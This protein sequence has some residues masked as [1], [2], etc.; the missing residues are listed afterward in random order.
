MKKSTKTILWAIGIVVVVIVVA[1]I[2]GA[3]NNAG[4]IKIGFIGS[5]TG[6]ASSL[7]QASKS[8]VEIAV[9][10][11]NKSGGINGR[12]IQ[13]IYE[14]GKC[15]A[16]SALSAGQ[17]LVNFDKVIAIIGGLCSSETSSFIKIASDAKIPVISYCSSAPSLSQSGPYFFRTYPSDSYQGKFAAEYAY[18]T[19]QVR[20]VAVLYHLSDWGTGIKD[21]FVKRFTELGGKVVGVEGTLQEVRDYKTQLTK[22][23]SANPDYIYMA[24]YAEGSLVAVQQIQDLGIK[25]KLLGTDSWNDSKFV[26]GVNKNADILYAGSTG[27]S[28]EVFQSKFIAFTG[29][30]QVPICA[31]QAY[32]AVTALV[33]AIKQVGTD[34]NKLPQA[35]R[36]QNFQ[37]VTGQVSFDGNG[38]I[39]SVG[40]VVK[41]I[42]DGQIIQIQ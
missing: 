33:L 9:D 36:S 17:K 24:M 23:K 2:R 40:Y 13:V 22:I 38:D 18:N 30:K 34:A 32:D 16:T 14:D 31:P 25:T 4:N 15:L 10:E 1:S 39:T 12:S 3:D 27:N 41:R 11:V 7:G 19:L 28:N 6:D 21:V 42:K 8:A 35:I 20:S 26:S 5:L 37:G 29:E